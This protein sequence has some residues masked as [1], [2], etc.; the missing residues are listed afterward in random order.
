VLEKADSLD[1][2]APG[3][4]VYDTTKRGPA[5]K[6][7][8]KLSAGGWLCRA[9]VQTVPLQSKLVSHRNRKNESQTGRPTFI[10]Y[11]A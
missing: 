7:F 8:T 2:P 4:L 3:C 9:C 5:N 10:K 11:L 1:H 6:S